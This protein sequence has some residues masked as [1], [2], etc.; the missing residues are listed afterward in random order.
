MN[1]SEIF[2]RRPIMTSLVMIGILVFGLFSYRM[3]PV[4][5]LPNV[6]FPTI[7]V[8]ATLPGASP[9]TM[10]SAVATPLE[11]QFSTIAG[12][13]S[14]NSSSAQGSTQITLQ[15]ALERSVDAA[16]LDVQSAISA[17]LRQLPAELPSP[18]SFRKVNPA[19]LPVYYLALTSQTLPLS[20][21]DEYAQTLLAQRISTV[22]GV[23]QVQVYGS[24]KYAVRAQL[25]PRAL[26]AKGIGIDEVA[27]ALAQHNVNL[28]TGTLYGERRTYTV[29]ATGQL[30]DAAKFRPMIV[31]YR[32]GAPVRLGELGRVL[33]SV[34][35]NKVAAWFSGQRGIVLAIQRQ[36]GTN[37]IQVVDS[38]RALLPVFRAQIPP[39]VEM[40]VLYDRSQSIRDSVND[41]QFSLLLALTL[42]VMVIFLFLRNLSA[43]LI[44]S[45]ALPLALIG[46]FCVM[47]LM[48]YSLD[49]LSLMALTL[50]VGFVVDDAIVVLENISRHLEMGESRWDATLKGTREISFTVVSMTLS[51]VAVFLPVL[52]MG[53]ILGRL[54][55]EFAV[56]IIAAVLVSGFRVSYP[57]AHVMQPL[58]AALRRSAPR[59]RLSGERGR[60][61][62]DET[63][64]RSQ[65][66]LGAA[67][68]QG[69]H[70]GV[71]RGVRRHR[72][73]VRRD[74]QR[75]SCRART[76][77][78]SLPSLRPPRTF[79]SMT[80]PGSNV[81]PPILCATILLSAPL[82]LSSAPAVQASRSTWDASS[83]A[84]SPT[85][86]GPRPM[87]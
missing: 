52:F 74:A 27:D 71:P 56:T 70:A 45:L 22:S 41:V 85:A 43:T 80:W 81:R 14:M 67:P 39:G 5:A 59:A 75:V 24:Q 61:R 8:T 64:L 72:L 58:A 33:D 11:K 57:H 55:H 13:D 18:P 83:S 42:V 6:D 32:N 87:K 35:N 62:R 17:S 69:H 26:V 21:V 50:C 53:G 29:Q 82:W 9:E 7:Q 65:P 15:F 4:A 3:L 20:A 31:T 84:S 68:S 54:L 60:L 30:Y 1:I 10:A 38:I 47:Y 25:D 77:A 2:I 78:R 19:D 40:S 76:P 28:P 86:N 49:N 46:A 44:P 51:L 63:S 37:T 12:L 16:A 48:G 36:P 79:P 73:A 23:A 34:E 66:E